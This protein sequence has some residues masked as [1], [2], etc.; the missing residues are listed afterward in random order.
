MGRQTNGQTG[1]HTVS[2]RR[3]YVDMY[4][5][6]KQQ[7]SSRRDEPK[8]K[9][10]RATTAPYCLW[11]QPTIELTSNFATAASVYCPSSSLPTGRSL[12]AHLGASTWSEI[13]GRWSGFSNLCARGSIGRP[14]LAQSIFRFDQK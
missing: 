13:W 2:A 1:R 11:H 4:G 10:K 3:R 8:T 6:Q 9:R 5:D 12:H 7:E 14:K